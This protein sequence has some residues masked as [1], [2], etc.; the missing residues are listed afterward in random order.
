MTL[1][2][3]FEVSNTKLHKI[4]T[5][6]EHDQIPLK[7]RPVKEILIPLRIERP[8]TAYVNYMYIY[9]ATGCYY[10]VN[11]PPSHRFCI[12]FS[13]FT[14]KFVCSQFECTP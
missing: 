8:T 1:S 3:K 12:R 13:L 7:M 10:E 9:D 14:I 5:K 2:T 11:I 4:N 6:I